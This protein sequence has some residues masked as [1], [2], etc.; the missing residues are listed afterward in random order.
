MDYKHFINPSFLTKRVAAE[1]ENVVII[2]FASKTDFWFQN[3]SCAACALFVVV[4]LAFFYNGW[5]F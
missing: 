1:A 3:V 2:Q 5:T 4:I